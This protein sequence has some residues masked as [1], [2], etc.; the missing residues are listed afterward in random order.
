MPETRKKTEEVEIVE[1]RT[2]RKK[3]KT[4]KPQVNE[5]LEE[6]VKDIRP[7]EYQPQNE[8]LQNIPSHLIETTPQATVAQIDQDHPTAKATPNIIGLKAPSQEQPLPQETESTYTDITSITAKALKTIGQ[9]ETYQVTE[10]TTQSTTSHFDSTFQPTTFTAQKEVTLTET[11][12]IEQVQTADVPLNLDT[13]QPSQTKADFNVTPQKVPQIELN[14]SNLKEDTFTVLQVDVKTLT[15]TKIP[16]QIV[17]TPATSQVTEISQEVEKGT[18]ELQVLPPHSVVTQEELRLQEKE[19]ERQYSTPEKSQATR[20]VESFEALQTTE[21]NVENQLGVYDENYKPTQATAGKTYTTMEGVNVEEFQL[22]DIPSDLTTEKNIEGEAFVSVCPQESVKTHEVQPALKEG[23]LADYTSPNE[24]SAT[25]SWVPQERPLIEEIQQGISE[26]K[27]EIIIPATVKPKFNIDSEEGVIVEEVMTGDKPGKYFPQAFVA[28]EIATKSIL[29]QKFLTETVI[30]A[31]EIEG[32][33]SPDKLPPSQLADLKISTDDSLIVSETMPQDKESTFTKAPSPERGVASEDVLLYESVQVSTVDSQAP[34]NDTKTKETERFTATIEILLKESVQGETTVTA[35]LEGIY[36]KTEVDTKTASTDFRPLEVSGQ[37]VVAVQES[38]SELAPD[39]IITKVLATQSVRPNESLVVEEVETGDTPEQFKDHLK[40]KTDQAVTDI[41]TSQA[42]TITETLANEQEIS[43]QEIQPEKVNIDSSYTRPQEQ[44][45]VTETQLMDSEKTLKDFESPESFKG[46]Q[47]TSH[48]L[49]AGLSELVTPELSSGELK[50]HKPE[51]GQASPSQPVLTEVVTSQAVPDEG[52]RKL[53]EEQPEQKMAASEILPQQALNILEVL[54]DQKEKPYETPETI[55]QE[56]NVDVTLTQVATQLQVQSNQQPGDL[57]ITKPEKQEATTD[58]T[59]IE[60]V[61]TLQHQLAEKESHYTREELEVKNAALNLTEGLGAPSITQITT[62]EKEDHYNEDIKPT[63]GLAAPGITSQEVALKTQTDAVLHT[64]DIPEEERI[65]GKAKK[66]TRPYTELIVTETNVADVEKDLPA[67]IVPYS[68]QANVDI[69]PGVAL[70][71]TE[72]VD[73]QKEGQLQVPEVDTSKAETAV[74][75]QQVA[76]QQETSSND[77]PGDFIQTAPETQLASTKQ[78]LSHSVVQTE[79]SPGE[80]ES[81]HPEDVKPDSKRAGIAFTEAEA[82][83]TT[84]V[85]AQDKEGDL[86]ESKTPQIAQSESSITTHPIA[87]KQ[88]VQPEDSLESIKPEERQSEIAQVDINPLDSVITTESVANEQEKDLDKEVQDLKSAQVD[89]QEAQPISVTNVTAALKESQ[90]KPDEISYSQADQLLT[91]LENLQ[92][93]ETLASDSLKDL[94]KDSPAEFTAAT[95]QSELLSLV[96]TELVLGEK[97][98]DLTEDVKPDQQSAGVNYEEVISAQTTETVATEKEGTQEVSETETKTAETSF[99]LQP[100]AEVSEVASHDTIT[101]KIEDVVSSAT[102]EVEQ[103]TLDSVTHLETM[104]QESETLFDKFEVDLKTAEIDYS[105]QKAIAV[106]EVKPHETGE[107]IPAEETPKGKTAE[108]DLEGREVPVKLL[109]EL[110]DNF[111]DLEV[112]QPT[113]SEAVMDLTALPTAQ[114]TETLTNEAEDKKIEIEKTDQKQAEISMDFEESIA[115]HEVTL[116]DTEEQLSTL[117]QDFKEAIQD[118]TESKVI[119][120]QSQVDTH[121][122]VAQLEEAQPQTGSAIGDLI[123]LDIVTQTEQVLVESEK[124]IADFHKPTTVSANV[125]VEATEGVFSHEVQ[126]GD[127]EQSLEEFILPEGRQA[128]QGVDVL[129]KIAE[130]DLPDVCENP[131]LLKDLDTQTYQAQPSQDLLSSLQITESRTEERE[132]TFADKFQPESSQVEVLLEKTKTV[133]TIS[134]L[135]T[136]EKES[137]LDSK[138][139]PLEQSALVSLD[140][141][142]VAQVTETITGENAGISEDMKPQSYQASTTQ[143]ELQPIIEESSQV[144]DR[145]GLHEEKLPLNEQH[146]GINIDSEHA[147]QTSEIVSAERESILDESPKPLEG[148][149]DASVPGKVIAEVLEVQTSDQ[150]GDFK[151]EAPVSS[152]AEQDQQPLDYVSQSVNIVLEGLGEQESPEVASKTA[153]TSYN[154]LTHVGVT[155]VQ[156]QDNYLDKPKEDLRTEVAETSVDEAKALEQSQVSVHDSLNDLKEEEQYLQVSH[157]IQDTLQSIIESE[158]VIHDSEKGIEISQPDM[159]TAGFSVDELTCLEVSHTAVQDKEAP[160]KLGET[161]QETPVVSVIPVQ[162]IIQAETQAND[163]LDQLSITAPKQ[164]SA[165]FIQDELQSLITSEYKTEECEEVFKEQQPEGSKAETYYVPSHSLNISET[166]TEDKEE[167]FKD[168]PQLEVVADKIVIPQEATKVQ[169]TLSE[170]HFEDLGIQRLQDYTAL[171]ETIPH[172]SVSVSQNVSAEKEGEY[173]KDILPELGA[174]SVDL[175][176]LQQRVASTYE[177]L[178]SL[179]EE[180]LQPE[181]ATVDKATP[182][183]TELKVIQETE[184]NATYTLGDFSQVKVPSSQVKTNLEDLKTVATTTDILDTLVEG[185]MQITETKKDTATL[186]ML[187]QKSLE[188]I[189]VELYDTLGVDSKADLQEGHQALPALQDLNIAATTTE[190]LTSLNEAELKPD[191]LKL[192]IATPGVVE[193]KAPQGEDVKVYD[194]L[195]DDI[196]PTAPSSSVASINI[197]DTSKAVNVSEVEI[198]E[199]ETVLKVD[200]TQTDVA[201]FTVTELIVTQY[202]D[203]KTLE[204]LGVDIKDKH[205]LTASADI[206]ME[207]G[208]KALNVSE[209]LTC[210]NESEL[211]TEQP[212]ADVASLQLSEQHGIEKLDVKTLDSLDKPVHIVQPVSDTAGVELEK[213]G[214]AAQTLETLSS[215]MEVVFTSEVPKKDTA[216][217]SFLERQV[218]EGLDVKSLDNLGVLPEDEQPN[219]GGATVDLEEASKL[220]LV[221]ETLT[222]LLES[223]L[224]EDKVPKGRAGFTVDELVMLQEEET[225]TLEAA[226]EFPEEAPAPRQIATQHSEEFHSLTETTVTLQGST[227]DV[228]LDQPQSTSA[229]LDITTTQSIT[230]TDTVVHGS[231]GSEVTIVTATET[232]ATKKVQP[233]VVV[234]NE[235]VELLETVI[236]VKPDHPRTSRAQ[237]DYSDMNRSVIVTEQTVSGMVTPFDLESPNKKTVKVTLA[238]T[239]TPSLLINEVRTHEHSGKS[240]PPTYNLRYQYVAFGR[241]TKSNKVPT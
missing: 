195:G 145:E 214:Q 70:S 192:D 28:T 53:E 58:Q 159:K 49:P 129:Q 148:Q 178:T 150:T 204:S 175:E 89:F 83:S 116:A 197:D 184:I 235:D 118:L 114:Q 220:P 32:L 44:L 51:E 234:S 191:D 122:Q 186:S 225:K 35:E 236:P 19:T 34:Q 17:E 102:A 24:M 128:I 170:Q 79:I 50:P 182:E 74:E 231:L 10:N 46:K 109:V 26:D 7:L 210:T 166:L 169:E 13:K 106:T 130:H 163:N 207:E 57:P 227:K 88:L 203:V 156:L 9:I 31:P 211:N 229:N 59:T 95:T 45:K 78:N 190:V 104:V 183:V 21:Q 193:Q 124:D 68:K 209:V 138:E 69:L 42:K 185:E 237:S 212:K 80:K 90:L 177:V 206:D 152:T 167:V 143:E 52:L 8:L 176:N 66:Y 230:I 189:E 125:E 61:Y 172:T 171:K 217:T 4:R 76:V 108:V 223:E 75:E 23:D 22:G 110:R 30:Q 127:K 219:L 97:E 119:A 2:I 29:T 107:S 15:E 164:V 168:V 99:D 92:V 43:Y 194:S 67:D 71:V 123:P 137:P 147:P 12:Q 100:V 60:A 126:T 208:S 38:E 131:G 158:V 103:T 160:Y 93:G 162:P 196:K 94:D 40:Y 233:K 6:D 139:T 91:P 205:P 111:T 239:E 154:T 121:E 113:S 117:Q 240:T 56:A 181:Q 136:Q 202:Q 98:R 77:Q 63:V 86:A 133:V 155:E 39:E 187:K 3:V 241:C 48:L 120:S 165:E 96:E 174:A 14:Q 146:A 65:T 188:L 144:Y 151:T 73:S 16:K 85:L 41:E 199:A 224:P 222:N 112:L 201:N 216:K 36:E 27:M 82:A 1:T 173:I 105:T 180:E 140:S 81:L 47:V 135:V 221:R 200:Q 64:D 226:E 87:S 11:L 238:D 5:Y 142:S 161:I 33:Y 37:T 115:V 218:V 132:T 101:S 18:A 153:D 149:A 25:K 54:A 134:E 213:A 84:Q 141:E 232:I 62:N 20:T 179:L 55:T 215:Q 72:T 157:M 198:S 228:E